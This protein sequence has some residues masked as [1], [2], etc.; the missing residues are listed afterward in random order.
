MY[1]VEIVDGSGT[2]AEF[3]VP[4]PLIALDLVL[5]ALRA[6]LHW[7]VLDGSV[8]RSLQ[9][10]D[11]RHRARQHAADDET[12]AAQLA[13]CERDHRRADRASLN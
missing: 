1:S 13:L 4:S 8:D 7:R 10:E 3:T 5:R 2:A 6:G 9:L 11:L 12:A